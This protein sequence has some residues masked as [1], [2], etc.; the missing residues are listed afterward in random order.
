MFTK[1][2]KLTS[3]ADTNLQK[4]AF[5]KPSRGTSEARDE[6]QSTKMLKFRCSNELC[7]FMQSAAFTLAEVLITL[8]IIGVV[9]AMT[10]PTLIANHQKQTYVTGLKKALSVS[11]NM[12]KQMQ[13]D[14]GVSDVGSTEIF[15]KS[16]LCQSTQDDLDTCMGNTTSVFKRIIPKY[17]KVLKIVELSDCKTEIQDDAF[18]DAQNKKL[19][20]YDT[21]TPFNE[22]YYRDWSNLLAFYTTDG[23]IYYIVPF[24]NNWILFIVDINGEKGPNI[25]GRDIFEFG[26][27]N[28]GKIDMGDIPVWRGT[29][30][31]EY[32]MG[33]GY[34]MDY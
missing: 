9:A 7:R 8:A 32:L 17:L 23:M 3:I 27:N 15:T 1:K 22:T 33:N 19:T 31:V 18:L 2:N 30:V 5:T 10:L 14:E 6:F 34:N 4:A 24:R 26:I 16:V 13:A 12:F 21:P 29:P 11:S 25:V 28:K 20:V